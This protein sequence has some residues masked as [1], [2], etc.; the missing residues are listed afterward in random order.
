MSDKIE[1]GE[2]WKTSTSTTKL[3]SIEF[4]TL[5]LYK[6]KGES[7]VRRE[8]E[9]VCVRDGEKY[10]V[11]RASS[12]SNVTEHTQTLLREEHL[13]IQLLPSQLR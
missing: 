6:I 11:Q 9:C 7:D 13:P 12:V 2:Q 4:S 8:E 1:S 10:K 3:N 5:K